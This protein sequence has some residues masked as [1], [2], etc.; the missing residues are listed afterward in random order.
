MIK[1]DKVECGD[2][3]QEALFARSPRS[4]PCTLNALYGLLRAF[5]ARITCILGVFHAR[6]ASFNAPGFGA[7]EMWF[8]L[9]TAVSL[10]AVRC[11]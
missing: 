7:S 1:Q 5:V 11:A 2:C 6:E 10:N 8:F 4:E 3:N 9:V